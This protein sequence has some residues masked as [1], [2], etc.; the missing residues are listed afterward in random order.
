MVA[1]I[2]YSP[3]ELLWV[4][5]SQTSVLGGTSLRSPDIGDS[6]LTCLQLFI[7]LPANTLIR[8][9]T[10]HRFRSHE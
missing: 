7:Q 9:F 4:I 10:A 8:F 3:E 6:G 1:D 5:T 2:S